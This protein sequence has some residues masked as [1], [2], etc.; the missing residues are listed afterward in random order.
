MQVLI[1]RG[2][3]WH[4]QVPYNDEVDESKV[5]PIV[6]VG[7]SDF[8]TKDDHNILVVPSSTFDGDPSKAKSSDLSLAD[9]KAAGLSA[10]SFIRTRRVMSLH[11]S[12]I[13]WERKMRGTLVKSDWEAV[14]SGI[15]LMFATAQY[16]AVPGANV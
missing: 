3:V 8:G 14:L 5:R 16:A 11:P 4:A 9:W 1:Q 6:I 13:L 12:M 10:G 15:G 7:W 2:Q